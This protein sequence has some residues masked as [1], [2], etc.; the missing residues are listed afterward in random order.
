MRARNA[1]LALAG[2]AAWLPLHAQTT[3]EGPQLYRV[4]INFRDGNDAGAVTDR[5]YSLLA[6]DSRKAVFKV[7]SKTPVVSGSA[8]AQSGNALAST[9]VT[10]L[11]VGVNIDCVVASLGPKASL[12]GDLDL[13]TVS[14]ESQVASGVRE[15][16]I[17]QTK[18]DLDAVMEFGKPTV[19]ASIDD[20]ITARKLQV[21]ATVTKAN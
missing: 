14:G 19:L 16:V 12:H 21:E 1:L 2:L 8:Q 3:K 18:L 5:R 6:L 4:E 20:P 17:R 7:G 11:D 9:Q 10:Y 13:S 15:P